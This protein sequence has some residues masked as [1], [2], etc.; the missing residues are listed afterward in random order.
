MKRV[1]WSP[2]ARRSLRQTSDFI[3]EVWNEQVR[4][5]F[6]NQLNFRVAQIQ[7]NPELAPTF[8]DS[9]IRKLVIHKSVSL[10]YQNFSEHI[11][12]LLIWDNRQNPAE[13]YR[14]LTDADKR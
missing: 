7:K 1:I 14:K 6:I 8:E 4:T 5:E 11:R 13:L 10:F 9:E 3:F 2:M 12:L